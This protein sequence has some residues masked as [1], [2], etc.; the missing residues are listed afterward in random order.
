MI[1]AV[2]PARGGSRGIPNKNIV[3]LAGRP[4]IEYTIRAARSAKLLDRTIVSTDSEA[5]AQVAKGLAAEV[6]FLRPERL[7]R[8]E[9]PG[10]DPIIHALEW[11]RD[12][13]HYLPEY[14]V[15]LQPTSPF[16]TSADID[17]AVELARRDKADSV[18]SVAPAGEHPYWMKR[19]RADGTLSDLIPMTGGVHRR[20]ELPPVYALNGAVYVARTEM[21]LFQRTLFP[22]P[23]YGYVMPA[24][25]S[26]DIDTVWDLRIAE[27]IL[28]Q[29]PE[30]ARETSKC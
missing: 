27:A 29:L 1:L 3:P 21:L 20:Q 28:G 11:I 17:A 13:D 30:Q 14:V 2:I 5:I 26:I 10:V 12:N 22:E 18:V 4:L 9:T 25:R 23:T 19:M 24:E 6:P 16:R 15:V 8:D 7:A